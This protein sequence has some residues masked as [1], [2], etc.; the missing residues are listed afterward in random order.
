M[1]LIDLWSVLAT[2]RSSRMSAEGDVGSRQGVGTITVRRPDAATIEWEEEG[3]W[4]DTA[5]RE[6][7]YTDRLRWTLD[8]PAHELS[9]HHLRQGEAHPVHLADLHD[10]GEGR[11]L[12]VLPH[13]CADDT[14]LVELR[15]AD[16]GIRMTW[17]VSGPRK[18]YSLER[19]YR[20]H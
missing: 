2:V 14:Y 4:Q 10:A 20:R 7:T 18:A 15:A 9:L 3:A 19:H 5:G 8:G 16:E 17:R 1:T 6:T 11:F 13:R 12:S